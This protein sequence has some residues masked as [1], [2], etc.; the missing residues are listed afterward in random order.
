MMRSVIE[1]SLFNRFFEREVSVALD[2]GYVKNPIYLSL[3]TEHIPPCINDAMWYC[4]MKRP[5]DFKLFAQ[6]RC[7][8]YYLS[9]GGDP[10]LL[11]KELCGR[12]GCNSGMGGSASISW[13]PGG[14]YG[15]SGLLGDQVPIGVG[16]AIAS[17]VRTVIVMGDGACEEDYVLGAMGHAVT[18]KASVLFVVEDNDLSILTQKKTRR[19]WNIVEVAKG[20]GMWAKSIQDT[21]RVIKLAI[22][23]FAMGCL[24]QPSLISIRCERERWHA[25]NGVDNQPKRH[26]LDDYIKNQGY[27]QYNIDIVKEEVSDIWKRVKNESA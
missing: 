25:G 21:P 1:Q 24:D 22:T 4:Y 17:G 12:S 15:H 10:Y 11:A 3:G 9:C 16:Y 26:S 2:E 14:M 20:M 19:S 6:H 8:S 23:E 5:G 13:K 27:G 18:H 7:H